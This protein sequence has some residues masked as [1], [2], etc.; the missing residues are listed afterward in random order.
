[1][2]LEGVPTSRDVEELVVALQVVGDHEGVASK[3]RVPTRREAEVL[4]LIADGYTT[5][6]AAHRLMLSECTVRRHVRNVCR[7]LGATSRAAAVAIAVERR[8]I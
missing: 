1:M 5:R 6:E 2:V 3:M 8:F 7:K 4:A